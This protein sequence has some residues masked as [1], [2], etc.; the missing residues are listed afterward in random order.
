MS[1]GGA[2]LSDL[3]PDA[4]RFPDEK[5][6]IV[7][8]SSMII[9]RRAQAMLAMNCRIGDGGDAFLLQY[10]HDLDVESLERRAPHVAGTIAVT[11]DVDVCRRDQFEEGL[12]PDQSGKIASLRDVLVDQAA[13]FFGAV[14]LERH[15]D[16]ERPEPA[17]SLQAVVEQ[18][19]ARG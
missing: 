2:L 12:G 5:L 14:L 3:V 18:P 1:S 4:N 15:P 11:H 6:Q 7:L 17:R 8:A 19:L 9:Y 13:E 16:L 10:E